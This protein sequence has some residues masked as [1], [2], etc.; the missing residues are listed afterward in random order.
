MLDSSEHCGS[1][2]ILICLLMRAAVLWEQIGCQGAKPPFN[3]VSNLI[4]DVFS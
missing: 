3:G 1:Y 4:Y 2:F